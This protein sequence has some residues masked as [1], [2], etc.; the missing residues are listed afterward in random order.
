MSVEALSPHVSTGTVWRLSSLLI[1]AFCGAFALTIWLFWDGIYRMW[2]SWIDSPEYSHA[3]LIPPIAAFLVWQQKDR[4]ERVLFTGSWWGVSL[5]LLGGALLV[6]GQLGTIYTLIQYAFLVTLFGLVLAFTGSAAFR[7]L[8]MPL[9]ILVLMVPLPQFVLANLSTKLQLLSSELGVWFMRLFDISVYLEGNVID[10]GGYKLQVEEACSGLRYLFPL[11]TLGFLMAYFY[12]GATWKRIALFLSSIPITLVMNSFR[13]G[14]IG[15]MVEHWGI[16]MAEGFLHEFQGWAVFMTSA[17]LMLGEIALLNRIGH[18]SGTWR[19]LFGIEFPAASPRGAPVAQRVLPSSF[20]AACAVL[21]VFAVIMALIP[22]P[23][24]IYP[25]R[26]SFADYPMQ[27]GRWNGR[28]ESME[29]VYLDALKLD[30]YLLADY[31]DPEGQSVNL[32]IA[33]YN[34]QRKGEAVHSPRSC[35]PGGGWQLEKFGQRTLEG[36]RVGGA[37]LRVNRTLIKLGDQRELVYYWF[38]QR[39]RVITNEFAVKWYLFWDALTRHRTDG[40]L[41]RL[42]TSLPPGS[43]EPSAD[44]RLVELAG[45]V[46]PTLPRYVPN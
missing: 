17:A 27:L 37:P 20:V 34:S 12:K 21:L 19:Q 15:F 2:G 29:G 25:P 4:L 9:F 3:L 43:D 5:V 32:Y 28:L 26:G 40:A 10:L 7:L 41:V 11:M 31:A 39:G 1:A 18:E 30:D 14:S 23:A 24:E 36:V 42:I 35:L 8:F 6:V 33:Y 13:V 38:Q 44:A 45:Q 46:A 22:R 16:G